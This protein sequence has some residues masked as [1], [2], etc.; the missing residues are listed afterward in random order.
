MHKCTS[1][2]IQESR[3]MSNYI[4]LRKL[5][6]IHWNGVSAG[7]LPCNSAHLYSIVCVGTYMAGTRVYYVI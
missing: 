6:E 5:A 4:Q 1:V 3:P 2:V 7:I